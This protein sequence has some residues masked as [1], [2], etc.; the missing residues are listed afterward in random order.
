MWMLR[1]QEIYTALTCVSLRLLLLALFLHRAL[2]VAPLL[3]IPPHER[4]L[5]LTTFA[6]GGCYWLLA[7]HLNRTNPCDGILLHRSSQ[8]M[9]FTNFTFL[10]FPTDVNKHYTCSFLKPNK[11]QLK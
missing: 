8:F 2:L 7:D 1:A 9:R 4:F 5:F 6:F 11:R 3:P 10:I